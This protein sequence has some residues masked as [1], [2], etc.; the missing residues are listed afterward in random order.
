MLNFYTN[1]YIFVVFRKS[2]IL[3][4]VR[5][6]VFPY[7]NIYSASAFSQH[8]K[9]CVYSFVNETAFYIVTITNKII[10]SSFRH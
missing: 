9:M 6:R 1:R 2:I 5:D 7:L 4:V 8:T 10:E 3:T